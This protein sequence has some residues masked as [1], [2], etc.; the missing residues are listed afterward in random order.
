MIGNGAMLRVS[1]TCTNQTTIETFI[2]VYSGFCPSVSDS[3]NSDFIC[4]AVSV[5]NPECSQV[6]TVQWQSVQ[7]RNYF[8]F[9]MGDGLNIHGDF[10]FILEE[11]YDDAQDINNVQPLQLTFTQE[12]L[13]MPSA[14]NN[15]CADAVKIIPGA[16]NL[17]VGSTVGASVDDVPLCP[18]RSPPPAPMVWFQ[19]DGTGKGMQASTCHDKTTFDSLIRVYESSGS[20]NDLLCVHTA[21]EVEPIDDNGFEYECLG[22]RIKWRSKPGK[23]YF[24][25]VY[26]WN[27]GST[28]QYAL[29]VQEIELASNDDC[30]NAPNID[31]KG[32]NTTLL[33][34]STLAAT[35]D[36]EELLCQGIY[37]AIG[38]RLDMPGVWYKLAA[39]ST[40]SGFG[41]STCT[42]ATEYDTKISVLQGDNCSG[43][44]CVEQ[45]DDAYGCGLSSSVSWKAYPGTFYYV[46]VHGYWGKQRIGM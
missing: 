43:L 17:I 41:V 11:V 31:F 25:I 30:V 42:N 12:D 39:T 33:Y 24:L 15:L 22:A 8:L 36:D 34:G 6:S 13:V 2:S 4:E 26:G 1:T 20:C 46:H 45:N 44:V 19:I 38:A 7:G 3:I 32:V 29:N 18:A 10:G 35:P 37:K 23:L 14:T 16:E 21:N 9:I 5:K 40:M 28:G 27:A